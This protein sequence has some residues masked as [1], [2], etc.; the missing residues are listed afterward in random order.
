VNPHGLYHPD[1]KTTAYE[2]ALIAKAAMQFDLFRSLVASKEYLRRPTNKTVGGESI[3]QGNKLLRPGKHFYRNAIGIK[4]GYIAMA[5]HTFVGA[6]E[7]EGR[8]LIAVLLGNEDR[9]QMFQDS[10]HL[11]E[12][13]FKIPR[14]NRLLFAAGPQNF[15]RSV[16]KGAG[17]LQTS[18][19]K[20]VAIRYYEGRE[21]KVRCQLE[22]QPT[23]QAPIQEGELVGHLIILDEEKELQ[24]APLYAAATLEKSAWNSRS[25]LLWVAG[26]AVFFLMSTLAWELRRKR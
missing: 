5:K 16:T 1:H 4:T 22:W 3:R 12:E 9:D 11:L 23:L 7:K 19:R 17:K 25:L 24:R 20:E 8:L 2:M 18:L 26:G 21:P 6:A 10:T 13:G 15:S 14:I